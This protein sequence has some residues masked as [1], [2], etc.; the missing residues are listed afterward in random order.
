MAARAK[1]SQTNDS[2]QDQP[3]GQFQDHGPVAK[4]SLLGD[5]PPVQ[6]QQGRQEQEEEDVRLQIHRRAGRQHDGG[7]QAD[8]HQ[9]QGD[10]RDP[11]NRARHHDG[12][13]QQQN[14][15]DQMHRSASQVGIQTLESP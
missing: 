2:E 9:W 10:A 13:K 14:G 11:R 5:P 12:Q 4:Q 1:E 7:P 6:K 3:Q 8:L 15:L